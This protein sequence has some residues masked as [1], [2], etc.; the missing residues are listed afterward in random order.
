MAEEHASTDPIT[1][2]PL[3]R[4]FPPETPAQARVDERN[5]FYES[6]P[7]E[8]KARFLDALT[9]A[10]DRGLSQDAAWEEAVLAAETAY[11]PDPTVP[12]DARAVDE[13]TLD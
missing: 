3:S 8:A 12:V 4:D 9:A 11:P 10:K 5:W 2:D 1:T 13:E 6:L 7:P